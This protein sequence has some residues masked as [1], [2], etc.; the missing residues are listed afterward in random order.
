VERPPVWSTQQAPLDAAVLVSER[1][2][3]V[4]HVLAVALEPE[5]TRLDDPGMDRAHGNF[6]HFIALDAEEVR[7]SNGRR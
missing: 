6:V 4:E 3:K 2:F 5:M 7:D 1:D